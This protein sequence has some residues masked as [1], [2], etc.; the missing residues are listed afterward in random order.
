MIGIG[1]NRKINKATTVWVKSIL[2]YCS[3]LLQC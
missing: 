1:L 3:N 2:V